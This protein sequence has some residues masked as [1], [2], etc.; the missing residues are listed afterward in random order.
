M[1]TITI[2]VQNEAYEHLL[3]VLKNIPKV[4]IVKESEHL[5]K[6]DILNSMRESSKEMKLIISGEKEEPTM[7]L[8]DLINEL[9]YEN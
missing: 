5:T 7:E 2:N 6:D 1:Q 8:K 3:Y 9:K 4:E